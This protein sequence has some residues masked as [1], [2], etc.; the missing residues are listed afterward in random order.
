[1]IAPNDKKERVVEREKPLPSVNAVVGAVGMPFH[2]PFT[3]P[4][5]QRQKKG[6]KNALPRTAPNHL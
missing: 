2:R 1:M 6:K 4:A 5:R 3:F